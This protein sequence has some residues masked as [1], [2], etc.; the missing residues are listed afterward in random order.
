MIYCVFDCCLESD[1][2][3]NEVAYEITPVLLDAGRLYQVLQRRY[4]FGPPPTIEVAK[5]NL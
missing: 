3:L 2:V 5:S 4:S 1:F